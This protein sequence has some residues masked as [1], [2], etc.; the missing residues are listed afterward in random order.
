MA[1]YVEDLAAAL[2]QATCY[3]APLAMGGGIKNKTM[4]AMACGLPVVGTPEAFS[5]MDVVSGHH[6]VSA[7][8]AAMAD[9]IVA[10]LRDATARLRIG[11]AAREWVLMNSSWDRAAEQ[12]ADVIERTAATGCSRPHLNST[13]AWATL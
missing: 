6:C 5:A 2:A 12:M 13:S 7:P 3:A 10:L 8:R 4:E 1:G 11:R 9:H